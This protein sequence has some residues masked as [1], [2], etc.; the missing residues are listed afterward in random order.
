MSN[1]L[2]NNGGRSYDFL[3]KPVK[4]DCNFIVDSANGNGLGLRSLK[5]AGV[6]SVKMN[7]QANPISGGLAM[8]LSRSYAVLGASTI[9][10]S[11]GSA[12]T[13]L[14]GNL[15]LYP[16]TLVTG[17][18]PATTSGS[19]NVANTA[20]INAQS[21]ALAA[22][23]AG[24]A[25]TA[26]TITA[27]L[28]GQT[29]T[30]GVYTESSGTFNL[31]TSGAGTLILNGAGTYIFIA[32]S[33]LVTGAGG[34]PTITLTG[35]ATAANVYWLVN[36]SATI[37]SGHGGTFQGNVIAHTSITVTTAGTVNG[38]LI[39]LNGA[40]TLTGATV[41]N[42][43]PVVSPTSGS[44]APGY[45]M[46]ELHNNYNR[47]VGGMTGFVSPTTGSPIAIN[48]TA[49][50][51]G[52]PYVI[53]S[54]GH[55]AL[56]TV[57]IAPVADSSSSLA[58]TYFRLYDAYGNTFNIWFSVDGKGSAPQNVA[59]TM[60][61]QS[62]HANDSA[63]TIGADLVTTINGLLASQLGNLSAPLG[64][65]SFTASGTTTVTVVST[66]TSPQGPLPG[67]P[68]DGITPTGFTFASTIYN[69]NL[70]N[71][72][73]VGLLPGVVPSVGAS[74]IA[75]STGQSTYGGSTG[76]VMAPGV[77]GIN[78]VEVIGDPNASIAPIPMGGSPHV[79]AKFLV[80][81]LATGGPTAPIDGTVV[82]M[83]FYVEAGS[84]LIAGE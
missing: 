64:V 68:F 35:G 58:G 57:T 7:S 19:T 10:S 60:V 59:G 3:E 17:F 74:F 71:W 4:I 48:S 69:T 67:A 84:M 16:G 70:E 45:A 23:T 24:N 72:Q 37:N 73:A 65:Y 44:I 22:F 34:T 83:T 5:G 50:T 29:L 31:A 62:I 54:V 15:G 81:F 75:T 53:V 47:Y 30:P 52:N 9:T 36:S 76:L 80:Q 32:S 13:T 12:G 11:D 25:M 78:S 49:L 8:G 56:G 38:S 63:A 39:A 28:D 2:G 26:T 66:S 33:T 61:Q 18:P 42:S 41:V 27:A 82:G 43:Q 6:R 46:I 21:N 14:S 77:S 40:V 55:A 20:A 79:G 51:I 1:K